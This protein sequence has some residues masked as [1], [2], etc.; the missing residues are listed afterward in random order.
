MR[1]GEQTVQ[2]TRTQFRLLDFLADSQGRVFRK[3]ELIK[4]AF[5]DAVT[6]HT[7]EQHVKEPRRK[8]GPNGGASRRSEDSATAYE[9]ISLVPPDKE[10][11]DSIFL[12]CGTIQGQRIWAGPPRP[13]RG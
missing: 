5:E 3:A 11:G 9:K 1:L 10:A 7:V 4:L 2:V 13:Q 12:V 8:L 6:E